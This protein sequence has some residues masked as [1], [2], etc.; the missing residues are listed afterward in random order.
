MIATV[1]VVVLDRTRV[2]GRQHELSS[3]AVTSIVSADVFNDA[4]MFFFSV[5]FPPP[6]MLRYSPA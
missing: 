5:I 2:A 1:T 3:D 4:G 6:S